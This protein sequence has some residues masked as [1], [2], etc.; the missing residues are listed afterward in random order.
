MFIGDHADDMQCAQRA[1]NVA[2]L[3]QNDKNEQF[4]PLA[5]VVVKRLSD[6]IELLEGGFEI[7]KAESGATA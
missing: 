7:T 2:C 5:H 4:V 6:V 1:G 3:L